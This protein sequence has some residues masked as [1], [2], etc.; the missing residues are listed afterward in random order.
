MKIKDFFVFLLIYPLLK[1][2]EVLPLSLSIFLCRSFLRVI[3]P[4][5]KRRFLSISKKNLKIAF[6][7]MSEDEIL[8]LSKESFLKL[9]EMIVFL[10]KLEKIYKSK[11]IFKYVFIDENEN[12]KRYKSEGKGVIFITAHFSVWEVLPIAYTTLGY[13]LHFVY[14]PI[15]NFY[16]NKYVLKRRSLNE[17]MFPVEKKNALRKMY[18][19]LK[20][21]EDVGILIDQNVLKKDGVFVDFFGK[22]AS[23]TPI[24]AYLSLKT[25][26]P[27]FPIFIIPTK[28]KYRYRLKV[29]EEIPM[30]REGDF[31]ELLKKN[32]E[33]IMKVFEKVIS[34]NP[35]NWLWI[36]RRWK[37]RPDGEEKIY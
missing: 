21:G 17:R 28:Q 15:D 9:S 29:F 8:K 16:F 26:A 27:I 11:K 36:H 5:L 35:E 4:F 31:N 18:K 33:K 6:P 3:S 2:F 22:K 7:D 14:R 10:A 23:T 34:E 24:A 20:R 19:A 32:S 30:E 13:K 37:T 25:G 1:T 12:F